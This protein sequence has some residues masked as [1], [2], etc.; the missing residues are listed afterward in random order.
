[1]TCRRILGIFVLGAITVIAGSAAG[2]ESQDDGAELNRMGLPDPTNQAPNFRIDTSRYD[3]DPKPAV[4]D[5]WEHRLDYLHA[6]VPKRLQEPITLTDARFAAPDEYRPIPQSRF[7][8]GLYGEVSDREGIEFRFSPQFDA[9]VSMPNIENRFRIFIESFRPGDLPGV[10][11]TE[12][13]SSQIGVRK[14]MEDF[15]LKADAGLRITWVPEL[16]ARLTWEDRW[17]LGAWRIGPQQRLFWET[18]DGFGEVTSIRVLRWFGKDQR[19]AWENISALKFTVD[20]GF[21]WQQGVQ[22]GRFKELIE[23]NWR[24]GNLSRQ[25]VAIGSMLGY[26]VFGEGRAITKHR[27][28]WCIRRPLR[29][30]WLFVE[31]KPGVEW[32]NERDWDPVPK[33]TVGIDML[34]WGTPDT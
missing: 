2:V 25:Q 31:L 4:F 27:V 19:W 15:N 29:K 32:E 24:G 30:R 18:D 17:A 23:E 28:E 8:M 1:M 12:Q 9:A 10:L 13:E 14:L 6:N 21:S 11:P 5:S 3:I 34:F 20:D 33:I 22:I 16:F 7:R 26:S